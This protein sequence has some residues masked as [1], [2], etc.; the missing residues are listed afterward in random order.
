M[1]IAALAR[2]DL[3]AASPGEEVAGT[4]ASLF[5]PGEAGAEADACLFAPDRVLIRAD[6]GSMLMSDCD[7]KL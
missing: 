1:F 7:G 3:M 6:D 2:L 4:D 5:A